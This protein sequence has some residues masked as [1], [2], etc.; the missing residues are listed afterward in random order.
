M[1]KPTK[2]DIL[3]A[4]AKGIIGS[5]PIAGA[6]AS[7]LLS[8]LIASPLEKRREKLLTEIG[9]KLKALEAAQKIKLEDLQ[10]NDQFVDTV[11]QSTTLALKTSEQEKIAAFKNAIINTAIDEAPDKTKSQIFLNYIDS[12]TSWHIK[13]LDLFDNPQK[14]FEKRSVSF[15]VYMGAGLS[16]VI[17]T[18]FPE[19]KSEDDLMDLI[20]DDLHRAG[21]H[22]T[23]GLKAMMTGNG[24]LAERTTDLGKE[25]L[26]FISEH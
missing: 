5:V 16:T 2:Q 4:G 24:L 11:L 18:A 21:F 20:W 26:R 10:N 19:F 15:P 17:E 9:E 1:T 3:Y 23:S 22:K 14:W 13:I 25:F 6:L 7:E 12:F 8:V